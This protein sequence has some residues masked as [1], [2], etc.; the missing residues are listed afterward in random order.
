MPESKKKK[1]SKLSENLKHH[2]AKWGDCV[3][4]PFP[5]FRIFLAQTAREKRAAGAVPGSQAPG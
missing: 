2:M 1:K 5:Q 4:E 3:F